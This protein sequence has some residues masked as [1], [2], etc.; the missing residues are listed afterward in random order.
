MNGII[1]FSPTSK[2]LKYPHQG[3]QGDPGTIPVQ[4]A[5]LYSALSKN[6]KVLRS[7]IALTMELR[8]PPDSSY[9]FSL[10]SSHLKLFPRQ[11]V[12]SEKASL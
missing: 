8:G 12:S 5:R 11:T 6:S 3:D 9:V 4:L 2:L 10:Q 7:E 1:I